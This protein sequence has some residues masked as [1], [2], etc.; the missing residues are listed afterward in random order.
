M[1]PSVIIA[2]FGKYTH[3]FLDNR[4]IGRGVSDLIYSAKNADGEPSP[5]LKLL[6][7]DLRNFIW[8]GA[9]FEEELVNL[10]VTEEEIR[11]ARERLE[12]K[13]AAWTKES[14]KAAEDTD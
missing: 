5:T 4:E 13:K 1:K 8:E 9:T 10:G 14:V 3:V 11:K 2:G 6:E 7:V 12:A